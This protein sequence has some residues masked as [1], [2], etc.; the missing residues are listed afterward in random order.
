MATS[1][2]TNVTLTVING[3]ITALM[4]GG[5]VAGETYLTSLDPALAAIPIVAWLEDEAIQ[6][7]A[8]I[9]TIAGEKFADQIAI[10]IQTGA[11]GN[12]VINAT[13]ALA[14]AQGTGNQSAIASA[15]AQASAA[16]QKAF[17]LDG[18]ATPS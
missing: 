8:N 11:E 17:G 9:L 2:V 3:L 15:A 14:L 6:Y 18:W 16:Y 5:I 4:S 10:S 13:T 12:N 1:P 7:I